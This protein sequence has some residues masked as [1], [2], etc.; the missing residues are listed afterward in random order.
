MALLIPRALVAGALCVAACASETWDNPYDP[1]SSA[2]RAPCADA[3]AAE[4]KEC[5]LWE[6]FDHGLGRWQAGTGVRIAKRDPTGKVASVL[7]IPACHGAATIEIDIAAAN[8]ALDLEWTGRTEPAVW[9]NGERVLLSKGPG[10][11]AGWYESFTDIAG[12]PGATARLTLAS[13]PGAGTCEG[14]GL[15]VAR[16]TLRRT[17]E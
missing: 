13:E 3:P 17:A 11:A 9:L 5:V 8:L 1:E 2:Y 10:E 6:E 12:R 7:A 4:R 15:Y 14:V 16:V